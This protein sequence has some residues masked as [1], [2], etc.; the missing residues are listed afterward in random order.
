MSTGVSRQVS[1]MQSQGVTSAGKG[2]K[3]IV[4]SKH[5]SHI[6]K[7]AAVCW[8]PVRSVADIC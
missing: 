8:K 6:I 7:R 2:S 1:R 5:V 3:V 4:D